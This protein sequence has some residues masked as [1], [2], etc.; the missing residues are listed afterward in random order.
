MQHWRSWH[1]QLDAFCGAWDVAAL[2]LRGYG[3]SSKPRG[4]AAYAVDRL[5]ADVAAVARKLG[6]G[7][8]VAL[9]G[10]DWGGARA[11]AG[12]RSLM[13]FYFYFHSFVCFY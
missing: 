3:E 13:L 9:V 10:H 4:K 1:R 8:P 5:A 7:A 2:D 6:G 12:A 11:R